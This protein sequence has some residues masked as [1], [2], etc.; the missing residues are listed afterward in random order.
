MNGTKLG[1]WTSPGDY[2]DKRGRFTPSWWKLGGSQYGAL[3]T[4]R[5][6]ER[7]TYVNDKRISAVTLGALKL[8]EHHSIRL[9][10]GIEEGAM[11]RVEDGHAWVRGTARAKLFRRGEP[12]LWVPAGAALPL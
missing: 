7:G 8:D 6:T 9:R 4:W 10:V 11:V 3:T 5:V 2:G 12:P 1:T